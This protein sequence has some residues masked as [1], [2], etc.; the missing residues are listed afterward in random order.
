MSQGVMSEASKVR[1]VITAHNVPAKKL[2]SELQ[3]IISAAGQPLPHVVEEVGRVQFECST[4]VIRLLTRLSLPDR[5]YAVIASVG[6]DEFP[7]DNLVA[8]IKRR[9]CGA[10]W[11]SA[12]AALRTAHAMSP[13]CSPTTIG[14]TGKRAGKRFAA[15]HRT[16]W[17]YLDYKVRWSRLCLPAH[18]P[19][20]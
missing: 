8:E 3:R 4:N 10:N 6:A 11:D 1:L 16:G 7:D 17:T 20:K 15:L 18:A 14:V 13:A 2:T 12:L 5:V 9:A 19:N